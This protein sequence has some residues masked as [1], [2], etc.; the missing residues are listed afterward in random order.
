MHM[1]FGYEINEVL[2][3]A[4]VAQVMDT[5]KRSSPVTGVL[6]LPSVLLACF[7]SRIKDT[8]PPFFDS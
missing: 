7:F 3:L 8:S 4:T 2:I 5:L 6:H 1:V